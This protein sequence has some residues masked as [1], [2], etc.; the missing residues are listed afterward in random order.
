MLTVYAFSTENWQR[1]PVEIAALMTIFS[2]YADSVKIES[3]AQNVRVRFFSTGTFW[4]IFWSGHQFIYL[5]RCLIYTDLDFDKLPP[6]VQRSITELEADTSHC[7]G[8]E[9]NI[10][11]SY[12][13]RQEI[14]AAC[15]NIAGKVAVGELAVEDIDENNFQDYLLTR[16]IPG[17]KFNYLTMS[18]Y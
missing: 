6:K 10:C 9:M 5:K 2:K 12:G 14:V 15:K 3:I 1:D 16:G 11:L 13:S 4:F 7:T 18:V 8:F 17:K